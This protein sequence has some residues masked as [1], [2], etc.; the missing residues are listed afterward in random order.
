MHWIALCFRVIRNVCKFIQLQI[1][2]TLSFFFYI[3]FVT[4]YVVFIYLFEFVKI[5]LIYFV[6]YNV[7]QVVL[8]I[9]S[10]LDMNKLIK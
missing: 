7:H 5:T 4:D 1:I 6:R 9:S 2:S 10:K 3:F 8:M